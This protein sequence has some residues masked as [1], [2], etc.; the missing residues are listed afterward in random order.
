MSEQPDELP[1]LDPGQ[2]TGG[3]PAGEDDPGAF[4]SQ[5]QSHPDEQTEPPQQ[6]E[7]ET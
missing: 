7:D 2:F 1:G 3:T 4:V 6:T 5:D